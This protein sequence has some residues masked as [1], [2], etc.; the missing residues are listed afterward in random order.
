MESSGSV[1][2][3]TQN[4]LV[5]NNIN[6]GSMTALVLAKPGEM[7]M[8][9]MGTTIGVMREPGVDDGTTDTITNYITFINKQIDYG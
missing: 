1:W 5:M 9:T 6:F 7:R 8:I 4:M 2:I 3:C